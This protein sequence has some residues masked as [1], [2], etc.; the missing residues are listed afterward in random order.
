M[1]YIAHRRF[2]GVDLNRKYVNIPFGFE[3]ESSNGILY[4]NG[5]WL[6]TERSSNCYQYFARNDDGNGLQRGKLTHEILTML[7]PL[8]YPRKVPPQ[9]EVLSQRQI[10]AVATKNGFLRSAWDR[11]WDDPRLR[12]F[13]RIEFA[14]DWIWNH[15]FYNAEISDLEYIINLIKGEGNVSNYNAK[16]S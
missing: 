11:I 8:S 4:Y 3:C 12:K 16:R 14:D 15:E 6:M 5:S 9:W 2:R 7:R 10:N 13:K 1:K